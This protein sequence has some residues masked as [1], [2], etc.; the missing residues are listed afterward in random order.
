MELAKEIG[1]HDPEK[2]KTYELLTQAI[3]EARDRGDIELL[4]T[5]AKDPQAFILKQ[6]WASVSIDGSRDLKELRSLYEYLQARI[7][8]LIETL[9]E[10][11]ASP[12]YEL[13]QYAEKDPAVIDQVVEAQRVELEKE[14]GELDAEAESKQR[15]IEELVGEV[16]F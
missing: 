2:R 10:L 16:P 11:R 3:N 4:E 15:E 6:G 14:I 12:D 5:I 8:E 13:F 1:K 9:D 7:L